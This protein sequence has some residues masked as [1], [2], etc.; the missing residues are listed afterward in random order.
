MKP[1]KFWLGNKVSKHRFV[2]DFGKAD[3]GWKAFGAITSNAL[4]YEG[5]IVE[6]SLVSRPGIM[7]LATWRKFKI[8]FQR[9]MDCIEKILAIV[10]SDGN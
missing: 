1:G 4:Q 2:F 7:V 8:I 9:I 6:F 3:Y 5:D 10:E